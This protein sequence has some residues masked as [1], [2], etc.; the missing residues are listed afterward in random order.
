M[1]AEVHLT[2][3]HALRKLEPLPL[4][5]LLSVT[6]FEGRVLD[7]ASDIPSKLRV[8]VLVIVAELH[9]ERLDVDRLHVASSQRVKEDV[10]FRF[11]DLSRT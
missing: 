2:S 6:G 4:L 3:G 5:E 8:Q 11:I 9:P 7:H 10:V 1:R